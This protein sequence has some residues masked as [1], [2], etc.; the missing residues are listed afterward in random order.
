[1]RRLNEWTMTVQAWPELLETPQQLGSLEVVH[2]NS[3]R[4]YKDAL[5]N[6][7]NSARIRQGVPGGPCLW[8]MT[9]N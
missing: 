7:N 8:R 6:Q 1:M 3:C 5:E 2:Y 9:S 4:G